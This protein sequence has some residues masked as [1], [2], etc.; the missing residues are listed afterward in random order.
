VI[1][2]SSKIDI[3]LFAGNNYSSGYNTHF[4]FQ[5]QSASRLATSN[6]SYVSIHAT[7]FLAASHAIHRVGTVVD[8]VKIFLSPILI[9]VQNLAAVCGHM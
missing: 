5:K 1:H 6:R 7:K 9:T 8:P 3:V 2:K 4:A